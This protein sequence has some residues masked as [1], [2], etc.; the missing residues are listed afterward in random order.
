MILM[1]NRK[2][3][4]FTVHVPP[5]HCLT[6]NHKHNEKIMYFDPKQKNHTR[7]IRTLSVQYTTII[8]YMK[9]SR[10]F[11]VST[12]KGQEISIN[13]CFVQH[14]YIYIIKIQV[15]DSPFLFTVFQYLSGSDR[16]TWAWGWCSAKFWTILRV[17]PWSVLR[18]MSIS[19][20]GVDTGIPFTS[21]ITSP[22]CKSPSK[23]NNIF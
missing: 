1:K 6:C 17:I 21:F 11:Q 22:T 20:S 10:I 3:N 16:D 8:T 23:I 12:K 4:P 18:M 19:C 5:E 14:S 9:L 13:T 15:N 2:L 7:K